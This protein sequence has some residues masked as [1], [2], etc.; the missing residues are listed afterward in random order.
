MKFLS[1][2]LK[3]VP[4]TIM[5]STSYLHPTSYICR[6]QRYWEK[7]LSY[8]VGFSFEKA[9]STVEKG[10]TSILLIL[11]RANNDAHPII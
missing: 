3:K 1:F 7:K 10:Y 11:S 2:Y 6:C 8:L 4:I 5:A 9:C